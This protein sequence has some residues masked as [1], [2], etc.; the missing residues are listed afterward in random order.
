MIKKCKTNFEMS[1]YGL[2]S[3][4]LKWRVQDSV[5]HYSFKFT[6]V[7]QCS[8]LKF[9]DPIR[10]FEIFL[11][12]DTNI[13]IAKRHILVKYKAIVGIVK[14]NFEEIIKWLTESFKE[15]LK[16]CDTQFRE[17]LAKQSVNATELRVKQLQ[18]VIERTIEFVQERL[19]LF[20]KA[21]EKGFRRIVRLLKENSELEERSVVL[22]IEDVGKDLG[23]VMQDLEKGLKLRL[24]DSRKES[25][26]GFLEI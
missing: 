13:C 18:K 6:D 12:N 5:R 25:V 1:V 3:E 9:H 20:C 23:F 14:R 2:H 4:T 8:R 11:Y 15:F 16:T 10:D 26:S 21:V 24:Q 17:Y 7:I 22:K 19:D